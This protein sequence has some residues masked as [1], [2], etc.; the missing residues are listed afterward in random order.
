MIVSLIGR[1]AVIALVWVAATEAS[2]SA[3]G[4]GAVALPLVV[5]VSY[6]LTGMPRRHRLGARARMR[7]ILLVGEL[8]GW[9]LWRSVV[10]GVDVARRALWVPR[11]DVDP[12]WIT[13]TTE[14]ETPT[15]RAALALVANL[16]PGSLTAS[17]EDR[18]LDVH[19]ISPAVDVAGSLAVL[20][21]RIARI[22]RAWS[23]RVGG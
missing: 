12:Q 2:L 7:G 16:M 5:A 19:A 17:L 15:A 9:V 18:T 6:V 11:A 1:L 14:L 20:E 3:L 8:A 23:V 21:R 22:E 10:G 13:H 4:Y